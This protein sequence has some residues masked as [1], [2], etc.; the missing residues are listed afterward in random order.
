MALIDVDTIIDKLLEVRVSRITQIFN[1]AKHSAVDT[2]ASRCFVANF[3][4]IDVYILGAFS[5]ATVF[6]SIEDML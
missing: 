6:I 3:K 1:P 2:F 5:L 4:I